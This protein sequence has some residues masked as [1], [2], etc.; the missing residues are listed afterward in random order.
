MAERI[1]DQVLCGHDRLLL[2]QLHGRARDHFSV[3]QFRIDQRPAEGIFHQQLLQ[4]K[5]GL[6]KGQLLLVGRNRT[7]RA[8]HL[9]WCQRA[10]LNLFLVVGKCFLRK[11]ERLIC[12]PNILIRKD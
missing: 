4:L 5:V 2:R 12:N 10:Y 3:R 8:N 11:R 7:L 9:N 1:I 6:G